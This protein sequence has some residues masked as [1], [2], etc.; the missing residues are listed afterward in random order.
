[1]ARDYGDRI[2]FLG[3]SS[4][5][6][7]GAMADFVE[8]FGVGHLPHAADPDGVLWERF[9][10]PYQ[11]A[12]VFIDSRGEAVRVFGAL[13]EVDLVSIL[14]DLADDRLPSG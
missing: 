14:E 9:G 11:P 3:V 4:R 13:P 5:D 10:V 8:G 1:V 2:G 7:V 6:S 12:W